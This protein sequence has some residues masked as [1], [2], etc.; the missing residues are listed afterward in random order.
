MGMAD[1]FGDKADFSGMDGKRGLALGRLVHGAVVE[2]NE[3]GTVAAAATFAEPFGG[4]PEKPV[5][6]RADRPFLFLIGL[7]KSGE[8]LFMGRMVDPSD[9]G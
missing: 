5:Y 8:I 9:G 3:K 4:E 7:T 6:F 1:V 2:V